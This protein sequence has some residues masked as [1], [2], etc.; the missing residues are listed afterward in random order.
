VTIVFVSTEID[1]F[2]VNSAE[3]TFHSG[4]ASD[5]SPSWPGQVHVS[6]G[7]LIVALPPLIASGTAL[8]SGPLQAK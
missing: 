4:L 7:T 5:S 8:L 3:S 1:A 6:Q 2:T